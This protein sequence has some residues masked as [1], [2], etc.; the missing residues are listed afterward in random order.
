MCYNNRLLLW[1]GGLGLG[2]LLCLG[3]S[4]GLA[5]LCLLNILWAGGSLGIVLLSWDLGDFNWSL[6]ASG[7]GFSLSLLGS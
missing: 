4:G 6:F 2:L 7:F 1:S 3:A 5:I